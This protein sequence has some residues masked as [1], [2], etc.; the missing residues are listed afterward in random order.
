MMKTNFWT[1]K[2]LFFLGLGLWLLLAGVGVLIQHHQEIQAKTH[3]DKVSATIV[4]THSTNE[5]HRN[6]SNTHCDS[7]KISYDY[8]HLVYHTHLNPTFPCHDSVRG[9][10]YTNDLKTRFPDGSA[11][12]IIVNPVN[13]AENSD[14]SFADTEPNFL[15][16]FFGYATIFLGLVS[17]LA[18]W[19]K[20]SPQVGNKK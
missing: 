7:I 1:V 19:A 18:L 20:D 6:G 13:P 5:H 9:I 16:D 8:N 17:I 11:I 3:W 10:D 2:K 15:F 4:S 14:L 12:S